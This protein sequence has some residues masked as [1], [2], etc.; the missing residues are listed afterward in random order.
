MTQRE[1]LMIS[2]WD[3]N[4]NAPSP[5][6]SFSAAINPAGYDI[7]R[8]VKLAPDN[9]T[10]GREAESLTLQE[11]I[12]DGTGV[13]PNPLGPPQ[14]VEQQMDAFNAVVGAEVEGEQ[15][16]YPVVQL[17]WGAL[18]YVGRVRCVNVKYTLFAPDGT[19]L[20]ARVTLSLVEY[21]KG[22]VKPERQE[23]TGLTRQI[24][25]PAG[26]SLP[27]LSFAAY[28]DPAL[29]L[30]IARTND[31]TSIRNLPPGMMLALPARP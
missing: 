18:Y 20:R 27:E 2:R 30:A 3:V 28:S 4:A 5:R 11:L 24:A 31:L 17:V 21:R 23:S 8:S 25:V 13:V 16:V 22:N 29:D 6:T 19:A 15:L 9:K 26:A 10:D 1:T 12:F 7:A 14:T